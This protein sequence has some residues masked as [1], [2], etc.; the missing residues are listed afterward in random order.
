MSTKTEIPFIKIFKKSW[1]NSEETIPLWTQ[2]FRSLVDQKEMIEEDRSA[3]AAIGAEYASTITEVVEPQ[4]K[5][6]E[7]LSLAG[8]V[9][10][11]YDTELYTRYMK[12]PFLTKNQMTKL[13]ETFN[14]FSM[15]RSLSLDIM[16]TT[17][18]SST[19]ATGQAQVADVL[20]LEESNKDNTEIEDKDTSLN[21][22]N[23]F[24][25]NSY[26]K[27]FQLITFQRAKRY[28][29]A[30]GCGFFVRLRK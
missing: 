23:S 4:L 22:A 20:E 2:V 15:E 17:T 10:L 21:I 14:D 3:F 25:E 1:V 13:L 30:S 9:A 16:E 24:S 6:L 5:K 19:I 7:Q 11:I 8:F 28:A 12:E 29:I 26:S 27:S 18:M